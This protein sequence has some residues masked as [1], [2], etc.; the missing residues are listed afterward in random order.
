MGVILREVS[1]K[2]KSTYFMILFIEGQEQ[3]KLTTSDRNQN[4]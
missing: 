1:E 4:S 2:A 3:A